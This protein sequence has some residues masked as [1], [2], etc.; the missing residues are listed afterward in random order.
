MRL[1][2][3]YAAEKS[4]W[5]GGRYCKSYGKL[6]ASGTQGGQIAVTGENVHASE[7]LL[8]F[9]RML[10]ETATAALSPFWPTITRTSASFIFARG[11][12]FG[13][14]GG[15]AEVSGYGILGFS[16]YADLSATRGLMGEAFAGSDFCG[17]SQRPYQ[18]PACFSYILSAQAL[19]NSMRTANVTVQ[20]DQFIDVGTKMAAYN[21][22]NALV[23]A[24]LN[25]LTG[26]GNIDLSTWVGLVPYFPFIGS[27]TTAGS[28]TFDTA[29][30]N[31]NKDVKMGNGNFNVDADIVNLN[32][33]L[34]DKNSNLLGDARIS[35]NAIRLM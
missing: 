7:T 1:P 5:G 29:T 8:N 31:I 13:G 22:G 14:N 23:D 21:T 35:S 33:V 9:M 12:E 2:F 18:Q 34:K 30:L 15:N 19:A 16:G 32:G 28:I 4:S 10:L 3:L 26:A 17:H 20:A 11:G 6:N 24:A 25:T 27:G